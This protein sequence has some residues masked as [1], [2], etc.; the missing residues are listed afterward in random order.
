[1][2]AILIGIVAGAFVEFV[3]PGHTMSEF[4]L[5]G[6][7]GIVGSLVTRFVGQKEGWFG[8]E[9]PQSFL[10]EILGA[11]I[12]LIGYIILARRN[13]RDHHGEDPTGSKQ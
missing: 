1:M 3:L 12:L 13:N 7:V 2:V 6:L 11:V 10:S 8:T 9:E 5:T 4:V